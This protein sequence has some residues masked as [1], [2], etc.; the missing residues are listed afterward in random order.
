MME[1]RVSRRENGVENRVSL[2]ENGV[3]DGERNGE[4]E[5]DGWLWV[6]LAGLRGR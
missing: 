2:M 5:S 1:N 3:S 6:R 4:Q